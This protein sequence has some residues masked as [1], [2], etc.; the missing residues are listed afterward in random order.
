MRNTTPAGR[1]GKRQQT[2]TPQ[3]KTRI[4]ETPARQ[5]DGTDFG[6]LLEQTVNVTQVQPLETRV[7]VIERALAAAGTFT[8]RTATLRLRRG[9][10][11]GTVVL[12]DVF[13]P[14]DIGQPVIISQ[15]VDRDFG[16]GGIVAFV[17]KVIDERRMRVGWFA[18]FPA[19][20]TVTINF[21]IGRGA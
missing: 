12:E 15:A 4:V 20:A 9:G 14:E 5:Q 10:R 11:S 1:A 8:V 3:S 21:A 6:L 18:G 13:E 7:E 2:S 16:E 19:P 17:A